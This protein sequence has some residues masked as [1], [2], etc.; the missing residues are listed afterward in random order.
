MQL[1]F[2]NIQF[3]QRNVRMSANLSLKTLCMHTLAA[4]ADV[5]CRHK[6]KG[7]NYES[8]NQNR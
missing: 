7:I 4:F 5:L 1:T 6:K 8:Y 2:V 3:A